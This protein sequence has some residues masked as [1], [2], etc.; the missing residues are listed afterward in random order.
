MAVSLE[1]LPEL[2]SEA[3]SQAR[4]HKQ[5]IG[6]GV[7]AV[8]AV[9]AVVV[10]HEV[11]SWLDM[12]V[13]KWAQDRYR[14]TVIHRQSAPIFNRFFN[15]LADSL[16]WSVRHTV[17]L[18]DNL[19]WPGVVAI[20][21]AIGWRTGGL[22]VALAGG[23]AMAGVGVIANWDHAMIT[24][25]IMAVS[26]IIALVLGI[27]LGIWAARSDRAERVIRILLDTAQVMPIFV[28][29]SPTQVFFGIGFP[30]A[31]VVT[32]IYALPPAVRLTSHGLRNVPTVINEVG[33][34]FGTTKWQQLTKV[35]LPVARKAILLGLN[36]VI[37][38]AFAIV[39]LAALLGTGDLGQ[40]VLTALQK[41]NLGAAA[42][43]G[44][45][46]VLLAVALDRVSTG[47]RSTR[48]SQWSKS[49]PT[50]SRQ[51][52]TWLAI[53][54]VVLVVLAS[55]AL[56]WS[57]FP[58]WLTYDI[59]KPVE[60]V[61]RW[62]ED[63]LRHTTNGISDFLVTN[64]L[65]PIRSLL[66]WLPWFFVV[67]AI[68]FTGW[69]SRG[70]RLA[71]G[72]GACMLLIAAMGTIP[73]GNGRVQL[74]DLAMDTL[75][76]VLVAITLS[77]LVALPLGMWAGRSDRVEKILRPFLDIAQVM[78]AFVYL[79]PVVILF[80]VGRAA[81]VIACVIYA[82]P[83]CS[84]LT[85]LGMREVPYTPREAAI[86]FGATPRQEMRRVQLPLAKKAILLGINQTLLMVLATVIIAS[87]VGAGALGIV[88]YEATTKPLS[89]LG[90]GVA[91]GVSIVLLAIVLDRITQAWGTTKQRGD[92]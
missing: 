39:V 60:H 78:P 53:S 72:V 91:G 1:A 16:R 81:G 89:K 36:Q 59:G 49:L 73:G 37:M 19:R 25:A 52:G 62:I 2:E 69:L 28:Y 74:W 54:A 5:L 82:V 84:R 57:R 8:L 22:R 50:V 51:V 41:Q 45:A 92:S 75:S 83:P 85:T 24:L 46:I 67:V 17:T 13:Q 87:L 29:F 38:M 48:R 14:W 33:E 44:G 32:V 42:A 20:T 43:A 27:P 11:P 55:H 47:E 35:Q 70:W 79:I 76:Q 12:N 66:L 56:D 30:G 6:L 71:A 15:P 40:D 88:A 18:L 77:M 58:S 61:R 26:V 7:F 63:H 3:V 90:Q 31:V 64:V 4:R 80:H 65:D 86:S 34:S 10:H 23:A 68:A 21:A 9:V